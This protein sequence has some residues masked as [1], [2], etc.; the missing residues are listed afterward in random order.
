ME[1][2]GCIEKVRRNSR[3][4]QKKGGMLQSAL[5]KMPDNKQGTCQVATD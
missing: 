3:P 5:V 4:R 1:N 2:K